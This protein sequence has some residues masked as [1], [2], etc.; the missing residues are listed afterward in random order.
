MHSGDALV[1]RLID[2]RRFLTFRY[3]FA[4]PTLTLALTSSP[5]IAAACC[6]DVTRLPEVELTERFRIGTEGRLSDGSLGDP[7]ALLTLP[8]GRILVADAAA[9]KVK[10]YD[11]RG[12]YVRSFGSRGRGPSQFLSLFSLSLDGERVVVGDGHRRAFSVWTVD[13]VF[14]EETLLPAAD[15]WPRQV[16]L[17]RDSWILLQLSA[18]VLDEPATPAETML[19]QA[20]SRD[21][22]QVVREF[23][24]AQHLVSLSTP[25]ER[26]LH[27]GRPGYFVV[28]EGGVVFASL[29]YRGNLVR[30][31]KNGS[32]VEMRGF[33]PP[34]PSL[35]FVSAEEVVD[36]LTVFDLGS[37]DGTT[38]H[39]VAQSETLALFR[40]SDGQLVHIV[41]LDDGHEPALI[42]QDFSGLGVHTGTSRIGLLSQEAVDGLVHDVLWMSEEGLLFVLTYP[43]DG[44]VPQIRALEFPEGSLGH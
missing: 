24:S 19:F 28:A 17:A 9:M 2:A 8:D 22:R 37:R 40:R 33:A 11:P 32:S 42:R 27:L 18:R 3:W 16:L 7:R 14:L 38:S 39:L 31:D 23:G 30:I 15:A 29:A 43:D 12:A 1:C 25:A 36:Y 41:R 10:V 35:R 4:L 34:Y 5:S 21:F 20:R 26:A 44:F 6:R 13:G